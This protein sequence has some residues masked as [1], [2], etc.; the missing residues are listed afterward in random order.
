MRAQVVSWI[1]LTVIVAVTSYALFLPDFF[2]PHDFLHGAR[3]AEMS[4]MLQEGQ[5]P[6]RWSG[7]FGYG[8]GMPLFAFYAPLPYFVSSALHL[9]GLPLLS[10]VQVL[11]LLP[12]VIAAVGSFYLGKRLFG[13]PAGI[14][15]SALYTLAPYRAVNLYVRGAVSESWAMAAYP[16]IVLSLVAIY[17]REWWGKYLLLVGL[18]ILLLSHNISVLLFA[19][20][21]V[22]AVG[23]LLLV[24]WLDTERKKRFVSVIRDLLF[25]TVF[26]G[27]LSAF[28]LVPAFVEKSYTQVESRIATGDFSF[29]HHFVYPRQL[30]VPRWGFGGS[31]PGPEDG[32]SFFVGYPQLALFL[33]A[34]VLSAWWMGALALKLLQKKTVSY[35][36]VITSSSARTVAL[37]ALTAGVLFLTLRYSAPI[38]DSVPLLSFAQFPWRWLGVS[39]LLLSMLGASVFKQIVPTR[40]RLIVAVAGSVLITLLHF[41]YFKPERYLDDASEF[42]FSDPERIRSEMSDVLPDYFPSSFSE[43]SPPTS[44]LRVETDGE[45][46]TDTGLPIQVVQSFSHHKILKFSLEQPSELSASVAVY[47]GWVV[48]LNSTLVPHT[49]SD[50]GL[51]AFSAPAGTH[52]LELRLRKTSLQQWSDILS[53]FALFALIVLA[54]SAILSSRNTPAKRKSTKT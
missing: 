54:S 16:V 7:N 15:L 33:A 28:Y 49:T 8:Y 48:L 23:V 43:S 32:L 25:G 9:L 10:A 3:V 14:L 41:D 53:L 44:Y 47:P 52:T 36:T 46:S 12:S 30:L 5:L 4:R 42:Y 21:V 38:W 40:W 2:R 45:L 20:V 50:T 31:I 19:P 6:P 27:L 51:I 39:A 22:A 1:V 26:A 37:S 29:E 11:F 17:A 34:G 18:V 13:A 24:S 35:S